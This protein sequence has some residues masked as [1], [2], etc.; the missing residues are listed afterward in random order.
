MDFNGQGAATLLSTEDS[1]RK[2]LDAWG[3]TSHLCSQFDKLATLLIEYRAEA[4]KLSKIGG[5]GRLDLEDLINEVDAVGPRIGED[6]AIKAKLRRMKRV[7]STLE[8]FDELSRSLVNGRVTNRDGSSSIGVLRTLTDA[9]SQLKSLIAISEKDSNDFHL[10]SVNIN[11]QS[12]WQNTASFA[13]EQ[14]ADDDENTLGLADA[15]SMFQEAKRL[16]SRA[17][18]IIVDHAGLLRVEPQ[19]CDQYIRRLRELDRLCRKI[20]VKNATEANK[21]AKV[22]NH[23][24]TYNL[25][26]PFIMSS[27]FL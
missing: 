11:T 20:G 8:R 23:W 5:A 21:A 25:D 3:G 24:M 9:S 18:S 16:I 27:P 6:A 17:E 14:T 19:V 12:D 7:Q 1:Q 26:S 13:E 4:Q 22:R 2:L 15:L 10:S